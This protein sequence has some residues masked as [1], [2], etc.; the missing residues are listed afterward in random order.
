MGKLEEQLKARL[1][2][3]YDIS[4]WH[5]DVRE[6]FYH[7][8]EVYGALMAQEA[9]LRGVTQSQHYNITPVANARRIYPLPART[10]KVLREEP[11]PMGADVQWRWANQRLEYQH[12]NKW[13]A[14][15]YDEGPYR[16]FAPTGPRI[17]LWASLKRSP[18]REEQVEVDPNDP[19]PESEL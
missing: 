5:P 16:I 9:F 11:D 2:T 13:I 12:E 6:R 18:Y 15:G 19:W 3:E 14:L 4:T 17:D 7:D 10:R 1:D 8:V